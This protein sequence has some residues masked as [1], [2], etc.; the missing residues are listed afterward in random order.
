MACVDK[1]N[2]LDVTL[3]GMK[4]LITLH[5]EDLYNSPTVQIIPVIKYHVNTVKHSIIKQLQKKR[6][7]F[8]FIA[9]ICCNW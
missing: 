5:K 1:A 8:T 2:T 3:P 7:V 6:D 4:V 9:S